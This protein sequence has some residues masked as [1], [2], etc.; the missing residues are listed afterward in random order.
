MD[1]EWKERD[2]GFEFTK[3]VNMLILGITYVWRRIEE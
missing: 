2:D 3:V 1:W